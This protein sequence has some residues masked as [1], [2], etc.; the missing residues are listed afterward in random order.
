LASNPPDIETMVKTMLTRHGVVVT[1]AGVLKGGNTRKYKKYL[2]KQRSKSKKIQ[3][4]GFLYGKNKSTNSVSTQPT[5]S[6]STSTNS[7]YSKKQNSLKKGKKN[8]A[9]GISRRSKR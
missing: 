4:G 6:L 3:R 9:R 1:N 5:A 8:R 2:H 7:N